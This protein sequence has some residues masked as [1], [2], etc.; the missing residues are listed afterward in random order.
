MNK[1]GLL[2][3]GLCVV[4]AGCISQTQ[5]GATTGTNDQNS[6]I[7][8][9]TPSGPQGQAG[10]GFFSQE[11]VDACAGKSENSSCG[12]KI[13]ETDVSGVCR[14]RQTGELTCFPSN[15]SRFSSN[16]SR[17]MMNN[18]GGPQ[19]QW[20]GQRPPAGQGIPAGN[21]ADALGSN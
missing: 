21:T 3:V 18:T 9:D 13:N 2:L 6:I 17:R 20:Q 15:M 1:T 11:A 7:P 10:R 19:G 8:Q 12:F 14:S 16:M 4:I 5:E